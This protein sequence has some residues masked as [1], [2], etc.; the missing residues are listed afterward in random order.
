VI[1]PVVAR[2]IR[3][4]GLDVD[5]VLTDGG[6][7][8]GMALGQGLELKRFDIQDG[9]GIQLLR[10]AGLRVVLVSGRVSSAT[11]V[12]AEDL[13]VDEVIQDDLARKLPAFERVLERMQL[14]LD[15]A[16]FLGDDLPDIPILRRVGL[17][18]AVGNAVAEVKV[19]ARHVTAAGGGRGA[20]REFAQDFL[21]ARGEWDDAV[22]RYLAERGEVA[23][24]VSR[25]G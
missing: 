14:R 16:A 24:R 25:A 23:G 17:P 4:V 13:G 21:R 3:V 15:D 10:S 8:M 1:E 11:T 22:G 5:G 9:I 18:V 20:V 2:R 19:I 7:Y 6:V 12:R